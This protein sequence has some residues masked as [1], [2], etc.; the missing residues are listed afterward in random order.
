MK[1]HKVYYIKLWDPLFPEFFG[2]G[3]AAP[4]PGLS[5]DAK[6]DFEYHM[7]LIL[8]TDDFKFNSEEFPSLQFALET[9]KRDLSS[10]GNKKIFET[11]FFSSKKA[12]PIN[13]LI[14]M[15]DR[16]FM[17][18]QVLEKIRQGYST[19]KLKIGAINFEEEL[20]LIKGIRKE[21]NY[22]ELVIRL[23][24]NGA[25]NPTFALENLKLLSDYHIHSIEQP[26]KQGQIEKN[27]RT[28]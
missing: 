21:Y 16:D 1:A 5:I 23:D 3:E 4:L 2:L 18:R 12:I 17:K 14:W 22:D 7:D 9:A 13:G 24:A 25:F 8:S 6:A 28:L 15:G 19:I 26:I 11:D 10:K 27:G 20:E